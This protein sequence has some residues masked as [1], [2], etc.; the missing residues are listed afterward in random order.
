MNVTNE[1]WL[2]R[3]A[4]TGAFAWSVSL[5]VR[6]AEAFET[7][8][9]ERILLLGIFVIVPLGLSL[10]ITRRGHSPPL[11]ARSISA[12]EP[13]A[14]VAAFISL[15]LDPGT[16][17]AALVLPWLLVTTLIAVIGLWRLL[18]T[19]LRRP[20]EIS[21]SAGLIYLPIGAVWLLAYR[22]GLH[23]IGFGDT[24]VLL[25]AVHFHFAGFAAPILAGLTASW[26]ATGASKT[27]LVPVAVV[28]VIAG[29]P[30][31]ATG[32]TSS[33]PIALVGALVISAGLLAL[34]IL[35]LTNVV[36]TLKSS[37]VQV[38][39]VISSLAVL[40]AMALACA[41]AYSIVFK[42]LI[43]DIPQMAMTHGVI[44]AFGFVLCGLAAWTILESS[45]PVN[46]QDV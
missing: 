44:N 1:D 26:P 7:E 15:L 39:L 37:I 29:T 12:C 5:L 8:L 22:L 2:R 36:R 25:T 34:A 19:R 42:K 40:P 33:P 21:I 46:D 31:V 6:T 27:L 18:Q 11:L 45:P 14:A 3:L 17:A 16:V 41:Y 24:I 13:V 30:L 20:A 32:I 10:T 28:G 35:N 23:P 4:F 9:I 43:I 38:L